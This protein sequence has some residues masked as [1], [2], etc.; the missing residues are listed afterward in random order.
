MCKPCV[1]FPSRVV[2]LSELAPYS[3]HRPW[4]VDPAEVRLRRDLRSPAVSGDPLSEDVLV[5]SIDP[6]GCQDVD[7]TL[8]VRILSREHQR[9]VQLGVHIADV[10][11]F[12]PHG[13]YIDAEARKRST[14]VYLADRRYDMLPGLLCSDVCS[15]WSG[16]DR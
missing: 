1:F 10:T 12:V 4:Q 7:D 16:V 3:A 8:S 14:S 15:L 9:V 6:Q 5:F 2:Q 13:S 11:F